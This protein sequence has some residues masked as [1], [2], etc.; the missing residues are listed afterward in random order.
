MTD[1]VERAKSVLEGVTDGPWELIGGNEYITGVS[2][3]VAP[4]D[5]GVTGPDAA[6]IAAS[7]TL[8]PELVA[9]V[10]RLRSNLLQQDELV[11]RLEQGARRYRTEGRAEKGEGI[12]WALA[13]I[14]EMSDAATE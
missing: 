12:H 4:D 5:G 13:T 2:V 14:V 3:C 8:V 10:E 1:I 6:F 9:E 7:R 11:W